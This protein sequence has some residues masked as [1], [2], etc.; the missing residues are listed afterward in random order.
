MP[1]NPP[2]NVQKA[3]S[4]NRATRQAIIPAGSFSYIPGAPSQIQL[5]QVG[6]LANLW[7]AISATFTTAST[8]TYTIVDGPIPN[9]YGLINRV[10]LFTN[11]GNEIINVSAAG[12]Y[13][14]QR[15][16]RSSYDPRN[17]LASLGST[18]TAKAVYNA[19]T[20]TTSTTYTINFNFQI[21]VAWGAQ[22]QAGLILLQN[23]FTRITAELTFNDGTVSGN[24]ITLGGTTPSISAL[25]VSATLLMEIFNLPASTDSYPDLS[26]I[27]IQR[28]DLQPVVNTGQMTYNPVLGNT[29][30]DWIM[31]FENNGARMVPANFSQL[32]LVYSQTQA[33]YNMDIPSFL[34][35][36]RE[37]LGNIDLPDG[38]FWWPMS[39]GF[40][41]PEVGNTRDSINSKLLTA[42]Q[43]ITTIGT[44]VSLVNAQVRVISRQLAD[45]A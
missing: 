14:L 34:A 23:N 41:L 2:S 20:M 8:G 24:M 45:I 36:T 9:P 15:I 44:G 4:F 43:L 39:D 10:R 3:P 25:S 12:L 13:L 38:V 27:L 35:R 28:E 42:L 11:E 16:Q 7:L 5:P 33:V 22:L 40:G 37:L 32:Q 1:A 30:L 18:N 26:K 29:Y 19:P 31:Q 21:P 17:P 6:L